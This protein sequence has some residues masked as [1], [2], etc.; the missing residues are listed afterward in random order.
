M[1]YFCRYNNNGQ[2][3][4]YMSYLQDLPEPITVDGEERT[5]E[6]VEEELADVDVDVA[7]YLGALYEE[8]NNMIWEKEGIDKTV[9]PDAIKLIQV[10]VTFNGNPAVGVGVRGIANYRVQQEHKQYRFNIK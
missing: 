10:D 2:A 6:I 1:K 7:S 3:T 9:S 4:W 8:H 5:V